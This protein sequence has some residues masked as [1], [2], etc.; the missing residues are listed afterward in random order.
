MFLASLI[1]PPAVSG[2]FGG[3]RQVGRRLL[4]EQLEHASH[5]RSCQR[6]EC[7]DAGSAEGGAAM[8]DMICPCDLTSYPED[9]S[10]VDVEGAG[11][12]TRRSWPPAVTVRS[13][14]CRP[15]QWLELGSKH[16]LAWPSATRD[17]H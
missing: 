1:A 14:S 3:E 10:P 13:S 8:Q 17:H 6:S 11:S 9:R 16:A 15:L 12:T 5:V 4:M 7:D 2:E